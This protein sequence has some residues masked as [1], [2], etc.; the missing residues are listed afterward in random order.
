MP[1]GRSSERRCAVCAQPNLRGGHRRHP[2]PKRCERA[3]PRP[4]PPRGS[5]ERAVCGAQNV[6]RQ[7]PAVSGAE[8][9]RKLPRRPPPLPSIERSLISLAFCY[10]LFSGF[11][12]SSCARIARNFFSRIWSSLF[13]LHV[14]LLFSFFSFCECASLCAGAQDPPAVE[15]LRGPGA[16]AT[17][18]NSWVTKTHNVSFVRA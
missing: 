11:V 7:R 13:A 6:P 2:R 12:C 14:S 3:G 17:D 10:P 4:K 16:Y 5:K 8:P 15:L 18:T 1:W 9:E